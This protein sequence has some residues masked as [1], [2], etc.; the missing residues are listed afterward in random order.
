MLGKRSSLYVQDGVKKLE[1]EPGD[2]RKGLK[3][4]LAQSLDVHTCFQHSCV[5]A[6]YLTHALLTRYPG[7]SWKGRL[8]KSVG[9]P[10]DLIACPVHIEK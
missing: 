3:V 9:V 4:A 2:E 8:R 7:V 1:R 10:W 5:E 6:Y